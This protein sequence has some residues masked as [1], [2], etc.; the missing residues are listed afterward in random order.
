MMSSDKK[1]QVLVA[2]PT[3]LPKR[4]SFS[5]CLF[6]F[7]LNISSIARETYNQC[8]IYQFIHFVYIAAIQTDAIDLN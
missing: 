1:F 7:R 3:L 5:G 2:I 4:Q 8:E 6:D